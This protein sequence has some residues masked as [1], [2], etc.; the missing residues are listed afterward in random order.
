MILHQTFSTILFNLDNFVFVYTSL[1]NVIY[2]I[3]Q[4][5]FSNLV[6]VAQFRGLVEARH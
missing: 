5:L 3:V 2:F 4:K 1:M 6:E